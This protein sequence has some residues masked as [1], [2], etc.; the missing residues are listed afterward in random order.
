MDSDNKEKLYC[1]DDGEYR[2]YCCVCDKL[3]TDIYYNNHLES[4]TRI[5]IP[6]KRQQINNTNISTSYSTTNSPLNF[7][8]VV[9]FNL[10]QKR[11]FCYLK[12]SSFN[13]FIYK[14]IRPESQ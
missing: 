12:N 3:A 1:D 5:N 11:P 7:G 8:K 10:G 6:P 9:S 14:F 4:Q 13:L 2:I